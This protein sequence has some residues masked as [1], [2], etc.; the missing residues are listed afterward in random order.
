LIDNQLW[1]TATV[2]VGLSHTKVGIRIDAKVRAR[3][4]TE[5]GE[6]GRANDIRVPGDAPGPNFDL[7]LNADECLVTLDGT[8]T[9]SLVHYLVHQQIKP[10]ILNWRGR[11][12]SLPAVRYG[13]LQDFAGASL[14]YGDG[15]LVQYSGFALERDITETI[16]VSL[17]LPDSRAVASLGRSRRTSLEDV[18]GSK[19]RKAL[20]LQYACKTGGG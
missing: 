15:S 19:Q 7:I 13:C 4:T 3:S 20:V 6:L 18:I 16:G 10:L 9:T 8:E 12:L 2:A 17:I 11:G 1:T 14:T 5:C